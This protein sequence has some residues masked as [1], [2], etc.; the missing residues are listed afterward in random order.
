M[1]LTIPDGVTS[2]GKDVFWECQSL[3][4]VT[5]PDGVESI[6][7]GA[8]R[9]CSSLTSVTIPDSVES[10]GNYSFHYCPA[11]TSIKYCGTEAQW[12]AI[13]KESEWNLGT[14]AYTVTYN[15]TGK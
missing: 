7:S 3:A 8:F 14:D 9:F 13:A 15:Y 12:N 1:S 10:I 5:I 4:S 6:G 11:L 2:I